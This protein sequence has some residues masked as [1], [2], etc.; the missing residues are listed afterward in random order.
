[1]KWLAPA[2]LLVLSTECS[3]CALPV[4]RHALERWSVGD[5]RLEVP[6]GESSGALIRE[7]LTNAVG[8]IRIDRIDENTGA[9]LFSPG[10]T[11]PIWIGTFDR[12]SYE[13]ITV[14]PARTELIQ[15]ILSGHSAVWVLV[16]P[17]AE[18][19]ALREGLQL[20]ISQFEST[21]KLQDV[22]PA[23]LGMGPELKLKFS[24]LEL[25]LN[26]PVEANFVSAL[27][28]VQKPKNAFI[29]PVFGRGR[30]LGVMKP[31]AATPKNIEQTC[32]FLIDS[33]SCQLD[34]GW[35][36]LLAVDWNAE[37]RKAGQG[38]PGHFVETAP[39]TVVIGSVEAPKV[40]NRFRSVFLWGSIVILLM[41][42]AIWMLN[43]A[44]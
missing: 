39:E 22:S 26:D 3:A 10:S 15:R 33:C 7:L 41:G 11:T 23:D 44:T 20:A 35:D 17:E 40:S 36:L 12:E 42:G 6:A 37:L 4:F 25:D 14:S 21:G 8:N 34:V 16:A 30:V 43:R 38:T 29:A 13:R 31:E 18:R 24:I 27:A 1:M 19:G 9:V 5:Y 32:K 28:G 2:V